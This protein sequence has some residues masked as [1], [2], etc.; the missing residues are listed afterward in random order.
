MK[1]LEEAERHLNLA[2]KYLKEG[3]DSLK[4]V[5]NVFPTENGIIVFSS[6]RQVAR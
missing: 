2:K 3:I 4:T 6:L 5:G 1:Q